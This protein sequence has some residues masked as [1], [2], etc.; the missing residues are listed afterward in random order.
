MQRQDDGARRRQP[1][2]DR[3]Q[4]IQPVHPGHIDVEEHHIRLKLQ[5]QRKRLGT[6]LCLAANLPAFLAAQNRLQAKPHDRV[7]V[8]NQD[9]QWGANGDVSAAEYRKRVTLNDLARRK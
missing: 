2:P 4:G 9:T 8:G 3:F 1:F 6:R 7:V 5:C